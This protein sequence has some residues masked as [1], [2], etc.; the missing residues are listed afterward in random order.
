[1]KN[2]F[3][4]YLAACAVFSLSAASEPISYNLAAE[5]AGRLFENLQLDI[6]RA[7]PIFLQ[8]MK[9]GQEW[10]EALRSLTAENAHDGAD[11]VV[12]WLMVWNRCRYGSSPSTLISR[13]AYRLRDQFAINAAD[14]AKIKESLPSLEP[15]V[16]ELLYE[17][18][19]IDRIERCRRRDITIQVVDK[20]GHP[21]PGARVAL[22][23]TRHDFLFGCNVFRWE[24]RETPSQQSYRRLFA[25]LMNF[26]TIGFY[27]PAYER[28]PG[29]TRRAYAAGAAKWC[30]ENGIIVK[31]HPLVWNFTDPSWLPEDP[32]K[33]QPLLMARIKREIEDFKGLIEIW[34][35]VNEATVFD[36]KSFLQ[37]APKTTR[38]WQKAGQM[39][40]TIE[41]FKTARKANPRAELVINDYYLHNREQADN[42]SSI[43]GEKHEIYEDVLEA[44]VEENGEPLYDIIGVQSHMHN[45]A[46][47][48]KHI[49]SVVDR[50][51]NYKKPLHFTETTIVSGTKKEK[52]Q[53]E[54]TMEGE[55]RQAEEV[56]RFY[57]TVFSCPQVEALTWW[58]FSDDRAW[59]GAP[60]GLIRKDMSPKSAYERLLSLIK[61]EWWTQE[62]FLYEAE[63]VRT[64]AFLGDYTVAITSKDG[65]KWERKFSLQRGEEPI[66]I[67]IRMD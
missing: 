47:P 38:L 2:S 46:W 52:E 43:E 29:Q 54:T 9:L 31:G 17:L 63:P 19:A 18:E 40:L 66:D 27:W 58:D 44:L 12:K 55:W 37:R 28:A 7:Q 53:W 26:A 51:A 35:V 33:A 57:R 23:Q 8:K 49:L 11:G 62:E 60:A 67:T 65:K 34:D 22:Q 48:T 25:Q 39:E 20:N 59:Q 32:D 5:R 36:R 24:E 30:L 1:M 61:G 6:P 50:F 21:A 10:L 64:R 45:G 56:E 41:A 4:F 14:S 13:D 42:D 16:S 15:I 3:A